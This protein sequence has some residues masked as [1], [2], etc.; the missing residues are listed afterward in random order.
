MGKKQSYKY[1]KNE[2]ILYGINDEYELSMHEYSTLYSFFVTYSCCG[3]QS[4]KKRTFADYG[5]NEFS[6]KIGDNTP[7]PSKYLKD[8]LTRIIDLDDKSHFIFTD[9]DNL[10][11]CFA[12][13]NLTNEKLADYDVERAVIAKTNETNRYLK[14]FYRIRDGF[15]HGKF[16]L[17][18][19][20]NQEKMVVI[21]DDDSH[22]VTARII[23]KLQTLL[24]MIQVID[25]SV[26][27]QFSDRNN[28]A[29]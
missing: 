8:A 24:N 10:K 1:V 17:V 11:S 25:K 28:T 21:Q 26:L 2:S 9:D 29:Q 19:A 18:L 20:S 23:I 16:K 7:N 27:I 4:Y 13:V 12:A 3:T 14:L 5:W 6:R 15:A 22:N